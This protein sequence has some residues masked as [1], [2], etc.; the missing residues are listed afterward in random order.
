MIPWRRRWRT[1]ICELVHGRVLIVPRSMQDYNHWIFSFVV[2][3]LISRRLTF[4]FCA[5]NI[6][7]GRVGGRILD[8]KYDATGECCLCITY[9]CLCPRGMH[10]G[11]QE[12]AQMCSGV[13]QLP[14]S[15]RRTPLCN[16]VNYVVA[17]MNRVFVVVT[18]DLSLTTISSNCIGVIGLSA[19]GCWADTD[20]WSRNMLSGRGR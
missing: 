15:I 17:S 5:W 13:H 1:R 6:H 11:W 12:H 8:F 10:D 3:C 14:A 7:H 19:I 18:L 9:F 20:T 4:G 2:W 16:A